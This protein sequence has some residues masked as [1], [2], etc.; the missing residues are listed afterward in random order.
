M[1][2]QHSSLT[3]PSAKSY[4]TSRGLLC[5]LLRSKHTMT[6]QNVL[7]YMRWNICGIIVP[8]INDSLTSRPQTVCSECCTQ[9]AQNVLVPHCAAP[10]YLQAVVVTTS[11][12][13]WA[14]CG[15]NRSIEETDPTQMCCCHTGPCHVWNAESPQP[16]TQDFCQRY[17]DNLCSH[18]W[19]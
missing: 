3:L 9:Q 4:T 12:T 14:Q 18:R 17:C 7:C 11:L 10:T 13:L 15:V 8:L 19:R 1:K 16:K 6:Y 2:S 5:A